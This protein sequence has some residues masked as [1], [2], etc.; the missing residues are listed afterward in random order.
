M[1]RLIFSALFLEFKARMTVRVDYKRQ[2]GWR[3]SIWDSS[4]LNNASSGLLDR[5]EEYLAASLRN[6]HGGSLLMLN[7]PDSLS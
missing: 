5:Q 1:K 7:I 4:K 2:V 6:F 3:K